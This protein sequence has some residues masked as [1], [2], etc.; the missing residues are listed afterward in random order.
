MNNFLDNY[1][2]PKLNGEDI[3]HLNKCITWNEIEAA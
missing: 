3:N 2:E 1:D